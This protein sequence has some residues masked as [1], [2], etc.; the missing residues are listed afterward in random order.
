MYL[1]KVALACHLSHLYYPVAIDLYVRV[2][3]FKYRFIASEWIVPLGY[4]THCISGWSSYYYLLIVLLLQVMKT[5][6]TNPVD[7]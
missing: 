5:W 3:H 2:S 7:I 1:F 4:L 6:K